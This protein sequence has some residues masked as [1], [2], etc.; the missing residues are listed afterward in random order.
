MNNPLA[1]SVIDLRFSRRNLP[2]LI[3][4]VLVGEVMA[5]GTAAGQPHDLADLLMDADQKQFAVIFPKFKEH[6][7]KC[8]PFLISEIAQKLS[9]N[10][11]DEAKD[12]L[13]MRQANFVGQ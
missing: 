9:P 2:I 6:S 1:Q 4:V 13:A 5:S 12:K 8:V 7:E 10:A 11:S 3:A